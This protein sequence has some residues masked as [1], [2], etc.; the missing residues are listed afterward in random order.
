MGIVLTMLFFGNISKAQIYSQGKN[1]NS[2]HTFY[3][4]VELV[5]KPQGPSGFIAKVDF[6]GRRKDVEWYLKEGVEHKIFEDKDQMI[7]Y[8]DANGWIYLKSDYVK[9]R[10]SS[11]IRERYYF[12]KSMEKLSAEYE[13]DAT[14]KGILISE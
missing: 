7:A 8:L 4:N 13:T 11:V 1:I 14:I 2:Q 3:L 12:R 10:S 5:K 9:A 6:Y